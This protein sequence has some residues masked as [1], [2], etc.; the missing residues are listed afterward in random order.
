[1]SSSSS[2]GALAPQQAAAVISL[3]ATEPGA[4]L[5]KASA[6]GAI[7]LVDKI[8]KGQQPCAFIDAPSASNGY[9]PLMWAAKGGH[10]N[11][12]HL[13]L[14]KG[15]SKTGVAGCP[16]ISDDM[17]V[18]VA[19]WSTI[20]FDSATHTAI[21]RCPEIYMDILQQRDSNMLP[22]QPKA[23]LVGP[24]RW[25]D[26][27]SPQL[28]EVCAMLPDAQLHVIDK[29]D[30]NIEKLKEASNAAN[31]HASEYG[32][33]FS[34]YEFPESYRRVAQQLARELIPIDSMRQHLARV[35]F[36]HCGAEDMEWPV[37][38]YNIIVATYSAFYAVESFFKQ[39]DFDAIAK[40]SKNMLQSLAPGGTLY[41][42][43]AMDAAFENYLETDDRAKTHYTRAACV[44]PLQSS[45]VPWTMTGNTRKVEAGHIFRYQRKS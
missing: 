37:A 33:I 29:E 18:F 30:N 39:G 21:L 26:G 12:A 11:I 31:F 41:V 13:L 2:L 42:D 32:S 23:L 24:G 16:A 36:Q 4:A 6:T 5:R 43:L 40:L 10:R 25:R 28:V 7:A 8:I 38:K 27:S 19:T 44:F 1:M 9:T 45:Y 3:A 15:A 22:A 17:K 14:E 34:K 35:S 20:A